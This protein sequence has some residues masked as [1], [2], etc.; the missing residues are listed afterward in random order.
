[1]K[2]K[3]RTENDVLTSK[4]SGELAKSLLSS[5]MGKTISVAPLNPKKKV[6]KL[7]DDCAFSLGE[8]KVML[9]K[10]FYLVVE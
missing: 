9:Y 8:L 3:I 6:F 1:M 2:I 5:V 10:G 4:V 7:I